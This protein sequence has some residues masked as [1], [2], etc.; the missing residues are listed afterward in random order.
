MQTIGEN[1]MITNSISGGGFVVLGASGDIGSSVARRLAAGGSKVILAARPSEHLDTLADELDAPKRELDATNVAEVAACFKEAAEQFEA[2]AGAV[3]CVGSVLLK[4]AHL[5][6][7]DE[8]HDTIATNLTSAFA[9]VR[10]AGKTMAK[11]G[12]S[13][14]LMSSAAA[15][16]GLPSHEAIAAAK[17]GVVGLTRSAAASY[18]PR[19]IR[20]NA[21][22][23]GLVKTKLT[24]KIWESERAA[25]TSR[26]MHAIGRLGEPDE[27]A[28]LI[29]WLLDPANSWV[30]GEV[31]SIDGG[32]G[33][34]RLN[35]RPA[36]G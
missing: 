7:E 30:T 31:F 17:A 4:P 21:V 11:T 14:V 26:S 24:K 20:V 35:Q 12:G 28:S 8:W 10:A 6:S 29:C 22:A 27:V 34:V 1:E 36:A 15:Q 16:I 3:N 23:P 13:V 18:A 32:L 9:T 25:E 2:L 19:G 5:T 33:N